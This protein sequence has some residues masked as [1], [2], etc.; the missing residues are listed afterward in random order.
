MARS[1]RKILANRAKVSHLSA[2]S[3]Q[4]AIDFQANALRLLWQAK[5]TLR[6]VVDA[7]DE[8]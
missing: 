2:N 5:V 7:K 6:E 3:M 1:E 4:N 8:G